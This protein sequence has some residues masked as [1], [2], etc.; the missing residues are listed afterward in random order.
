ARPHHPAPAGDEPAV[1]AASAGPAA[2]RRRQA[3]AGPADRRGPPEARP[4]MIAHALARSGGALVRPRATSAALLPDE[5]RRDG[6]L[7]ILLYAVG[8]RLLPLGDAVADF[9][10]MASFSALPT[11]LAGLAVLIPWLVATLGIEAILG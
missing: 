5:G 4:R 10:A 3:A 8:A 9:A 11:L 1:S 7:F 2:G 6:L